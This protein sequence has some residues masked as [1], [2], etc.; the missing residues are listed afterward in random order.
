MST[1]SISFPSLPVRSSPQISPPTTLT[2]GGSP[3]TS[4]ADRLAAPP[5]RPRPGGTPASH[6]VRANLHRCRSIPGALFVFLLIPMLIY[7]PHNGRMIFLK[8]SE[9][10]TLSSETHGFSP[11]ADRPR[12]HGPVTLAHMTRD[13]GQKHSA[14]HPP[15]LRCALPTKGCFLLASFNLGRNHLSAKRLFLSL[16][17]GLLYFLSRCPASALRSTLSQPVSCFTEFVF[18][19]YSCAARKQTQCLHD[20]SWNSLINMW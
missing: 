20:S 4:P 15:L 2:Q 13:P 14:L 12:P 7:F 8:A 16:L 9:Y 1:L 3:L 10:V 6:R 5:R 19:F 11:C 18:H 17:E